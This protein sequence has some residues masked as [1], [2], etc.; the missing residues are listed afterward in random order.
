MLRCVL[1]HSVVSL[2]SVALLV[3]IGALPASGQVIDIG[4]DRQLFVDDYLIESTEQLRLELGVPQ[5]GGVAFKFDQ[6]WDGLYSAYVTVLKGDNSYQMY[7]RGLA[8]HALDGSNNEV[9]CY[10]ESKDGITW[11]R[12]EL[13]LFEFEGSKA[14]N[15]ILANDP[16]FAHNFSPFIDKRPGVPTDE[17][18]K[19]LAG[20]DNKVGLVAFFSADGIHWTRKTKEPVFNDT[21]EE[22]VFDS[23]NVAFWSESERKYVL[24]YRIYKDKIRLIARATSEDFV[25]WTKEGLMQYTN[26]APSF[27]E[28]LYT[29]QTTAYFRAP[30]I[31]IALAARFMEGREVLSVGDV[32]DGSTPVSWLTSACSDVVMLSTR[33]GATYHRTF[34]QALVRPGM[35]PVNW[36]AR[37]N[38]ASLGIV[39][40]GPSEMSFFVQREYG[41]NTHYLERMTLRLDG[42]ASVSA[43][44]TTGELITKPFKFAG[45]TL[46]MNY[47][48]SAAGSIAIEIQD[49]TGKPVEG[50]TLADSREMIGDHISAEAAWKSNTDLASLAGKTVRLRL[51]MKE[52]NLYSLRFFQK[53]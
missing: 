42:L 5:S 4:S 48:T 46:E 36:G 19:A 20:G 26:D 44:H 3:T 25:N 17:R 6:S 33:G 7:Y 10:A 11:T 52:S 24:Y 16:P 14:N 29:N 2:F 47:A 15:I 9:T 21:S 53:Q 35:A 13:N 31:Y 32:N 12:P 18:Y 8:V 1:R 43:D 28:Q 30:Q 38:Y 39:Q 49:E 50:F 37:G 27:Q 34:P 22:H 23:Q 51:V 40:S 41:L 45:N